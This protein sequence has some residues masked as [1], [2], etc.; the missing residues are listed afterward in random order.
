MDRWGESSET[1][2]TV[3]TQEASPS[4][5]AARPLA[6][7]IYLLGQRRW[8]KEGR[9]KVALLLDLQELSQ[10]GGAARET[11]QSCLAENK[12]SK[13]R[14]CGGAGEGSECWRGRTEL[15]P[16]C[17]GETDPGMCKGAERRGEGAAGSGD[18]RWAP[19]A[20]LEQVRMAFVKMRGGKQNTAP[21]AVL[22][23]GRKKTHSVTEYGPLRW[24]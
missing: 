11:G 18:P 4:S 1:K 7:F 5:P 13:R 17:R 24:V 21:P 6:R 9:A 10:S 20:E 23:V 8:F 22:G 15:L 19:E 12:R 3:P 14:G 2:T 16:R